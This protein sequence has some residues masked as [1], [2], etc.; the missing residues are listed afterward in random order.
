MLL[1]LLRHHILKH[2]KELPHK[3]LT[4]TITPSKE[5]PHDTRNPSDRKSKFKTNMVSVTTIIGES[6]VRNVFGDKLS[7]SLNNIHHV[8]VCSF[9]GAKTMYGGL[10]KTN[11][12]IIP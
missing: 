7:N 10:H 9:D 4:V 6:M 2:Y 3:S 12:Q 1:I 8:V 5:V 11:H